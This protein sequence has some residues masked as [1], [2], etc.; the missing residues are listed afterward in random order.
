[1]K[2]QPFEEN[3]VD[4]RHLDV[5]SVDPPGC[6]DI[7]D[8]LHVRFLPNGNY[9]VGVH[10]ADVSHFVRPGNAM[11]KEAAKRGTTVYL[12]DR[13]IDMLPELLGSDLCSLHENVDRYTFSCIWE[14]SPEA[15]VLSTVYQKSII[16]SRAAFTYNAAQERIE[17]SKYQDPVTKSLRVLNEL[18]KK[19]KQKR[20]EKGALVL[21]SPEVGFKMERDTNDPLEV[22]LKEL[23]DV[24]AM[25]EE[26]MLLANISV[27]RK[28]F[29]TFPQCAMLRRHPIPPK[30]NFENLLNALSSRGHTI[31]IDSNK[32]LAESL[33][34]IVF[35]DD[36]F[37]NKLVR[38]LTTRCMMQA[39][40][41]CSGMFQENDF[42]HYG[43]AM[44]IYTHFTS[45][46]RRYADVI[47]HR[48]LAAAI[49]AD[50]TYPELVSKEHIH[51]LCEN[52]N[53]RNRMA[54]RAS[55]SSI[56]LYTVLF[57]KDKQIEEEARVIR[58]MDN[59][60]VVLV[61]RYGVEGIVTTAEPGKPAFFKHNIANNTLE[62]E[63]TKT[64]IRIFDTVIIQI[65][66]ENSNTQKQQVKF[67]LV[68]PII[69]EMSVK[70]LEKPLTGDKAIEEM[71]KMVVVKKDKESKKK[72]KAEEPAATGEK[73]Q[74]SKKKKKQQNEEDDQEDDE[75]QEKGSPEQKKI[76]KKKQK[77][78]NE[79]PKKK[80]LKADSDD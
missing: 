30:S 16:H 76:K 3:R 23:K 49:G 71:Q 62:N 78:D 40:Y 41:I 59:G 26:F 19:F 65:K 32:S 9:E 47:V 36:P 33:D 45:P 56:E 29:N 66:V 58:I 2:N 12:V 50:S 61:P 27:A 42:V 46:I 54:Q 67:H 13:R 70:P 38:M 75:E 7:D 17:N 74:Q 34:S 60:F 37:M 24:N 11:D 73:D 1:V 18:A 57:F 31:Q 43:L 8:A 55:R 25:I 28:I 21:S 53:R 44:D 20:L 22:E 68:K 77:S 15:E 48:L 5:C 39:V 63:A 72:E 64:T 51:R 69:P 6:T 10:I 79:E 52:L 14:I 4:L 35:K 80:K